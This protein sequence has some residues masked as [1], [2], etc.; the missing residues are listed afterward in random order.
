MKLHPEAEHHCTDAGAAKLRECSCRLEL[1]TRPWSYFILYTLYF[2]APHEALELR[3]V[4]LL[5]LY[6]MLE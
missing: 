6:I 5:C 1:H 2:R 3:K 4:I